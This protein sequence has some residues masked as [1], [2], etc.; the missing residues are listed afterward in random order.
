M[1]KK[2]VDAH[3]VTIFRNY[4]I[5]SQRF[6]LAQTPDTYTAWLIS[7]EMANIALAQYADID[8]QNLNVITK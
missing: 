3:I 1:K 2:E 6:V 5:S 7:L 4:V 8:N